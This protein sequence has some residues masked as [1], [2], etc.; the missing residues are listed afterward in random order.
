MKKAAMLALLTA[1][2]TFVSAPNLWAA[3]P[4]ANDNNSAQ[5]AKPPKAKQKPFRGKVSAVDKDA[6]TFTV[7]ADNVYQITSES[8]LHKEGKPAVFEAVV[9]GEMVGG[10]AKENAAGKWEVVTLNIGA[11]GGPAKHESKKEE[12]K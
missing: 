8:K 12:Q 7:G 3:D 2:I 5:P 4:G 1:S 9:V 6:R 10:L 11:K